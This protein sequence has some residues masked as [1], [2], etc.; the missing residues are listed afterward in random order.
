GRCSYTACRSG[1]ANCDADFGDKNGCETPTTT[2]MDCGGCGNTCDTST[3]TPTSCAGG[4]CFYTCKSGFADCDSDAHDLNGCE[5]PTTTTSN[6][7]GCG[8][9]CDSL[10]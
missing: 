4:I 6:C 2:I 1:F 7:G 5:T 3:G 9:A 10:H 8:N